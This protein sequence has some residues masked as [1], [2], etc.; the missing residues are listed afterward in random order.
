V[1]YKK[2]KNKRN[3]SKQSSQNHNVIQKATKKKRGEKPL[4]VLNPKPKG[5][6]IMDLQG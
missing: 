4:Q 5:D 1:F 3:K 2:D 6:Q